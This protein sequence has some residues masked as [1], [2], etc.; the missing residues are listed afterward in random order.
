MEPE[1]SRHAIDQMAHRSIPKAIV[2]YVVLEPD[3]VMDQNESIRIY[4]KL[5]IIDAKKYVYRVFVNYTK[6]PMVIIT[7]YRTSKIEKY[8]Y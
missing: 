5:Y 3:T 7:V 2:L 8:G 6:I 1:F 4:S